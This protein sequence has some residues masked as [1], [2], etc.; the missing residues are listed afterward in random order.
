MF[1]FY[2]CHPIKLD[3]LVRVGNVHDGGYIL[4]KRQIEKT[5]ILLS[6]GVNDDWIFE[7][8]FTKIKDV[9]IYAYDYSIKDLPFY[10]RK[11]GKTYA[12]IIYNIL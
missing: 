10:S 2:K 8:E 1:D 9:K 4:S 5:D 7:K 6:F 12:A 3:N 11:F